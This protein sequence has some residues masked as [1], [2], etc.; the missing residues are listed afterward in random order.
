MGN[1]NE[2]QLPTGTTDSQ[3]VEDFADF[4]LNKIDRIREE[5]TNMP[6]YQPNEIDTPK[7]KN[8]T[9]ITQSQL[10]RTIKAMPTKSCQLNVIPTDKLKKVLGGYLPALTYIINKS[11]GTFLQ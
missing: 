4:F 7:L 8:F 6:T 3:L 11:L 1:K 9:P 2:S 10:E 5:F